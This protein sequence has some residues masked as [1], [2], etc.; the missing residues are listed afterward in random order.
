[1]CA[2]LVSRPLLCV[3]VAAATTAELRRQRDA[4]ADAD[5]VE[6]RLDSVS[7]PDVAAALDGRRRPVV[8]TCRPAWEGGG[9]KGSEEERKRILSDAIALGA[10]FVDIE[11]R[12]HFDDLIARTGGKRIVLSTHDFHGVPIDLTARAHAMR[13]TGAEV[14]KI[15]AATT[16]L[17]DCIPLLELGSGNGRGSSVIVIGMGPYG[18]A[19][20]VLSARFGSRWTYAGALSDIGQVGAEALLHAYHYRCTTRRSARRASTPCT[21]R[22]RRQAP[23]ISTASRAPS[24]SAAR[25]SPSR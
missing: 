9:F 2:I 12:A 19:T 5:L 21:C 13:S 25:A 8:I 1:L 18:F 22:F 20:R 11:W 4:V 17:S 16:S 24:A 7:D 3:T 14:V 23:T 15:A 10:E 6:L